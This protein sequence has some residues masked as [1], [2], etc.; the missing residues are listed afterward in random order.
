MMIFE[1]L[2]NPILD[3]SPLLKYMSCSHAVQY[4]IIRHFPGKLIDRTPA[5]AM[6]GNDIIGIKGFH[7]TDGW[8][9]DFFISP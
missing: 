8:I 5:G 6:H 1:E 9:N 2:R 4:E 7:L 3:E